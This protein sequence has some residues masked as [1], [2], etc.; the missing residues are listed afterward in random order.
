MS[1]GPAPVSR[2][3]HPRTVEAMLRQHSSMLDAL[4]YKYWRDNRSQAELQDFRAVADVAAWRAWQ[5]YDSTRGMQLRWW[6]YNKAEGA[7]RDFIRGMVG[8][9]S[10][11]SEAHSRRWS[12]PIE[13]LEEENLVSPLDSDP[14]IAFEIAMRPAALR[15]ELLSTI[16]RILPEAQAD[17]VRSIYFGGLSN[18]EIAKRRG[19]T[20]GNISLLHKRALEKL[21]RSLTPRRPGEL[22]ELQFP[23]QLRRPRVI[24][25]RPER[26]LSHGCENL[27]E[28]PSGIP[29][30]YRV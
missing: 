15:E 30:K 10:M 1:A 20:E 26:H 22:H 25:W 8:G 24:E 29:D 4:A 11:K 5:R 9:R 13:D 12:V 3:D 28:P 18:R 17:A 27:H 7:L 21:R 16:D 19:C 2:E 23:V 14:A 6:I